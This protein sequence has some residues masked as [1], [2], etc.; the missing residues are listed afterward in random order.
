VHR[1]IILT[2]KSHPFVDF[3]VLRLILG[4]AAAGM[5]INYEVSVQP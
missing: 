3:Q 1:E 2:C 5:R 4:Q